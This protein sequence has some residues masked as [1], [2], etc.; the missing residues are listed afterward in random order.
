MIQQQIKFWLLFPSRSS[1]WAPLD[2]F[3]CCCSIYLPGGP[4]LNTCCYAF[5]MRTSVC[6]NANLSFLSF[7]LVNRVQGGQL[8]TVVLGWPR[9]HTSQFRWFYQMFFLSTS[10]HNSKNLALTVLPCRMNFMMHNPLIVNP[11]PQK[12]IKNK[13]KR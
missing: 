2:C 6:P 12:K 1:P 11:P 7:F 9:L 5:V 8:G 4:V 13:K 10:G 3:Q